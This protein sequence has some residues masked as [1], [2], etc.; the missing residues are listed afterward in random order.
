MKKL[1]ATE[2]AALAERLPLWRVHE[3]GLSITRQFEFVDFAQAFGF[4]AHMAAHSERLN[5]H[6]EW[7]NVYNRVVVT[8]RTHDAQGLTHLDE[9]W[10]QAA[11]AYGVRER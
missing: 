6:P 2:V 5:H 11:D 7:S 3:D 10:A 1:S 9:A 4:M 8:L